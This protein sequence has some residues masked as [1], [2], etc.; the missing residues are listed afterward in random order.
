MRVVSLA[1]SNTEIVCA[2]GCAEMLVGVDDHS[3]RPEAVVSSLPRVGPDLRVDVAKVASLKPDLVL[4]SLTVPGHERNLEALAAA[5]LPF[6]APEPVSLEDVYGNI[7][8]IARALGVL[9]R[10]ERLVQEMRGSL[11]AT[12]AGDDRPSVL[13]QWWNRPTI[14]P[15]GLSWITDLLEH[16]GGENPIGGEPVKS[17]PLAD[18]EVAELN[19]EAIV[20]SW[21][22]VRP[23]KYRPEVV[24]RNPLWQD[25]AA[26]R[27]NRVFSIP[28]A[29]LGRPGPGLLAG[30]RAL[31]EIVERV[32]DG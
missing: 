12:P 13:V 25:V 11:V 14:A 19:P 29:A 18:D 27:E 15:G 8:E 21:C 10:G 5:G 26:V 2:L 16:A 6:L 4:A 23:E 22:G 1:C 32:A 30:F 3:D 17:R 24:L 9:E 20:L 28:E 31:Q 7:L